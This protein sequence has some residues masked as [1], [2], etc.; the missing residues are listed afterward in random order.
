MVDRII[1]RAITSLKANMVEINREHW[2]KDA[3]DA[4][5]VCF[6]FYFLNF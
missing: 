1:E 5:K 4:E 3:V 6:T 2:L